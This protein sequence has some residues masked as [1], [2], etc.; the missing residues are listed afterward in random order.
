MHIRLIR[1]DNW[2]E[3]DASII[4]RLMVASNDIMMSYQLDS[5]IKQR[6]S[7]STSEF[8]QG[9]RHYFVRLLAAQIFEAISIL[10]EIAN[11]QSMRNILDRNIEAKRA[12][13]RLLEYKDN[14]KF[15]KEWK[16]LLRIRNQAMFH[17]RTSGKLLTKN[18]KKRV[19]DG[20]KTSKIVFGEGT[21]M[22]F[23]LADELSEML[24]TY[25]SLG[26]YDGK[27]FQHALDESVSLLNNVQ[28][29]FAK[30][31]TVVILAELQNRFW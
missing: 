13:D 5:M 31:V 24:F 4:L 25:D 16:I 15:E 27:D 20:I 3:Q 23:V 29:D 7:P 1:L 30:V 28:K 21:P 8:D 26:H 10:P 11:S 18:L 14:G 12:Y 6:S 9:A 19:K 2:D 17:Y 22:R